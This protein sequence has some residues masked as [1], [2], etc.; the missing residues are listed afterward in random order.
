MKSLSFI[1]ISAMVVVG[2]AL[3]TLAGCTDINYPNGGYG[4]YGS[5]YGGYDNSYNDYDRH[6]DWEHDRHER[7]E[8]REMD[9][10]RDRL[11][12]ERRRLEAEREAARRQPP[13]ARRE[14]W[15]CPPGS[16]PSTHRCT[17]EERKRGCKDWGGP[18]GQG[19]SNF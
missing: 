10:E 13:P 1:R 16:H 5:S 15:H 19:C 4:G 7:H 12:D 9:R 3:A 6:R 14:E 17:K 8:R 11:E 2:S 18:N